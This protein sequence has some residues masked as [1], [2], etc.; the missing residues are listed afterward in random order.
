MESKTKLIMTFKANDDKRISISVD[1]PR[2]DLN[3]AEIISAMEIIL[4]RDIF[5]PNGA[6]LVSLIEAKVVTTDTTEY[7]LAL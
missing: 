7:D 2:A 4:A 1:N 6:T 5:A 3:E